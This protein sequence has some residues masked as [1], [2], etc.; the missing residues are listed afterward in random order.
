MHV[1]PE[2]SPT[3]RIAHQAAV[4]L[5]QGVTDH[6]SRAIAMAADSLNLHAHTR[7]SNSAVR[8]HAQAMRMQRLGS[9]GYAQDQRSL[10]VSVEELMTALDLAGIES[11]LMGRAAAGNV[12]G[13]IKVHLRL[14]TDRSMQELAQC[15]VEFGYAE[16]SFHTAQSAHGPLNRI[17]VVENN[18]PIIMTRCPNSLRIDRHVDLF[19]GRALACASLSELRKRLADA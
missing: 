4:L 18:V 13:D 12:D 15:L 6:V 1:P 8:Q 9:A 5:D 10:L 7:P 11:T 19:T 3:D 14:Y 16:P 17:T 2:P